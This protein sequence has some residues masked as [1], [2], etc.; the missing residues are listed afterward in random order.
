MTFTDVWHYNAKDIGA[1]VVYDDFFDLAA[2]GM[3]RVGDR[4][5][6]SISAKMLLSDIVDLMDT[7][8]E[9]IEGA[10]V[11]WKLSTKKG[12]WMMIPFAGGAT[13]S[14]IEPD[15]TFTTMTLPPAELK[16]LES[17][18]RERWGSD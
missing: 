18:L 17:A 14:S 5:A 4:W 6:T 2:L 3:C 8:K 11:E 16:A 9:M 13:L 7:L 12:T 1:R 10:M 15:G